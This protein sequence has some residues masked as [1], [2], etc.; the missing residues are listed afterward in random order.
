M[1]SEE[2][3]L[4]NEQKKQLVAMRDEV[5]TQRYNVGECLRLLK[6]LE[7]LVKANIASMQTQM[8]K[9]MK[10]TT[11]TQQCKFLL[12][13]ERHQAAITVLDQIYMAKKMVVVKKSEQEEE[14]HHMVDEERAAGG[15]ASAG[16]Q[17]RAP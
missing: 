14:D 15:S 12:W 10:I 4:T 2:C 1:L 13:I 3:Q 7:A 16:E 9:I 5:R 17:L 8:H 6:Q 11:P